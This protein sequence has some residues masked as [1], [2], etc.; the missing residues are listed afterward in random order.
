L[1]TCVLVL[2]GLSSPAAAVG[3]DNPGRYAHQQVIAGATTLPV[4]A[5]VLYRDAVLALEKG[6][7][8]SAEKSL[9][10]AITLD[11]E[12]ADPYLTLA[13]IRLAR[14]ELDGV[15]NLT[16]GLLAASTSFRG[17]SLLALNLAA[18][19]P[20]VLLTIAMIIG[21][22]FVI[23]YLPFVAHRIQ[24]SLRDRF[25]AAA[26]RA[27]T[28]LLLLIPFVVLPDPITML[29][30]LTVLCW[31]FMLRRERVVL[32]FVTLPLIFAG[33]FGSHLAAL[34]P[35]ADPGS[36][37]SL[38]ARANSSAADADLIEALGA[39]RVE[40]LEA[41]RNMALGLLQQR[42]G[43]YLG[44]YDHFRIAIAEKPED[45]SGYINLGNVYFMQGQYEKA[46]EGYRKAEGIAPEDPVCQYNLAQ[47]FIKTLLMKESSRAYQ[48]ALRLGVENIKGRYPR[49]AE[50]FLQV[51]P[52]TYP[53]REL[54]R[55]AAIEGGDGSGFLDGLLF[56]FGRF[57][58][59]ASAW[60]LLGSLLV[61]L[62]LS[63]LI[64]NDRL[65]FQCSN[66]ARLTCAGCCNTDHDMSLCR[67]CHNTIAN[68]S[69]EKVIEALLRQKRQ[70]AVVSR[71]RSARFV[72]SL[73]PGVRDIYYG[74]ITRGF[75]LAGLFSLS[76]VMLASRGFLIKDPSVLIVDVPLW[77]IVLPG[78]G[79]AV[80]FMVSILGKP[81][82]DFRTYRSHTHRMKDTGFDPT[83]HTR[84][85]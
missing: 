2:A 50:S 49:E 9:E 83:S 21:F 11:P 72:T 70:S 17:Q 62:A 71:R 57:S 14:L 31:L 12:Y 68:V 55:M 19:I 15:V 65:T 85:A 84:V 79:L 51:L 60:I 54:W 1:A 74:R 67:D 46:L 38:V 80:T 20:Y 69:S 10:R 4:P 36:L 7:R 39:S 28:Y 40:G 59:R 42:A 33:L 66:C 52:W 6:D 23:K 56:P 32:V 22:A 47:A 13:R 82:A 78:V 35:V 73:L 43:N 30:Y 25:N 53:N 29:A 18:I 58:H 76:L 24:E 48:N 41:E 34:T 77:K 3:S 8:A 61:A 37:T 44:A 26:P 27:A 81:K 16:Q 75:V 45:A 63:R 5:R 64:K